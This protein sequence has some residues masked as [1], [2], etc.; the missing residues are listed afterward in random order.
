MRSP[1][2]G[3][4]RVSAKTCFMS[5][6]QRQGAS[7]CNRHMITTIHLQ[8]THA[9]SMSLSANGVE[10]Q[11]HFSAPVWDEAEKLPT[12]TSY[13]HGKPSEYQR[14]AGRLQPMDRELIK[15]CDDPQGT[16]NKLS[17]YVWLCYF[18]A[19]RSC[20]LLLF[21]P[22]WYH[23]EALAKGFVLLTTHIVTS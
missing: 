1:C 20:S 23:Y 14:H 17:K 9:H 7:L 22:L 15:V 5:L 8:P 2:D 3:S 13:P 16:A 18:I 12:Q 19:H 10:R 4:C 11:L 21:D 6:R